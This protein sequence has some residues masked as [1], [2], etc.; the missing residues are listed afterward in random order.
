MR[1]N[2]SFFG[3]HYSFTMGLFGFTAVILLHICVEVSVRVNSDNAIMARLYRCIGDDC[4]FFL[5]SV[6]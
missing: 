1:Y 4:G 3:V 6:M 2:S 5:I